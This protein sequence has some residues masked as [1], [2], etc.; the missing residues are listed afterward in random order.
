MKIFLDSADVNEIR[1]AYEYPFLCGVTTNPALIAKATRKSSMKECEFLNHMNEIRQLTK[2][3]LF[4][5]TNST[6][7]NSIIHEAINIAK[8]IEAPFMIKIPATN[9]GLKAIFALE[10]D[11]IPTA[12]T[13]VYTPVQGAAAFSCHTHYI[14]PY[15]SRM[16]R[17]GLNSMDIIAQLLTSAMES[18]GEERLLVASIKNYAD[19]ERLYSSGVRVF[20]LSLDLIKL[21]AF[22]QHT[23][24]AVEEFGKLLAIEKRAE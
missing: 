1:Q 19:I 23:V 7:S 8:N 13:A 11:G 4:I 14:I 3:E 18:G 9:E 22:S 5:Q 12:A 6:D 21:I 15:F 17:N 2:G 16:E 24:D 20:T 10:Q